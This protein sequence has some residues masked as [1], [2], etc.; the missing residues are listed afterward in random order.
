VKNPAGSYY[1]V[2]QEHPIEYVHGR[3]PLG[4]LLNQSTAPVAHLTRDTSW[5]KLDFCQVAFIDVETTG[6][7]GG[8][9]TICFLVGVGYFPKGD[10]WCFRVRQFFMR[11]L[12]EEPA[13]LFSLAE[14]LSR[15]EALVSFNGRAFDWPLLQARFTLARM[16]IPLIGA[17]HLDLLAP[18]RQL[19]RG[20][21][22][23][24]AL[25]SLEIHI[26]GTH[27][28]VTDVPGWLIPEMYR[29]YLLQG[30]AAE[31]P[32]IFYHNQQD[33][34][35]LVALTAHLNALIDDPFAHASSGAEWLN[36]GR[37]YEEL[38]WI[39]RSKIAYRRALE[40]P[41]SREAKANVVRRLSFLL[42]RSGRYDEAAQLWRAIIADDGR[43]LYPYVELA[44]Y[45]EWHVG[46]LMLAAL[47]TEEALNSLER[48]CSPWQRAAAQAE[49]RHRLTRLRRKLRRE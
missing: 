44:K 43:E 38:G 29:N 1:Q 45:Y 6:L 48:I 41:L 2:E 16:P 17:P 4:A 30:D 39:E 5:H 12:P 14:F 25:S 24:C 27:R 32:A 33:I 23:S 13:L 22:H 3:W 19:W 9:G 49:L 18:A 46:K 31:M 7:A 15:F 36:L 20:S 47:V 26:L 40:S 42:K 28:A 35:S 21:L 34:L 37:L 8:T 10:S 11:D